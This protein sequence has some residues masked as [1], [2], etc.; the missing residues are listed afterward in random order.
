MKRGRHTPE[1]IIRKSREAERML[2]GG[3]TIPDA[4]KELGVSEQ[5]HHRWRNQ[6]GGMKA[7]D[8]N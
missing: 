4:A 3:K 6:Y 1:R 5:T 2:G 7:D 8:A